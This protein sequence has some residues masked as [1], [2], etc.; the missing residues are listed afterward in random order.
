MIKTI[1]TAAAALALFLSPLPAMAQDA[2]PM[3]D[4]QKKQIEALI[5]D[6]LMANPQVIMDSVE[7]FRQRSEEEANSAYDAKIKASADKLYNNPASPVVGNKDGDVTL[8]EFIDYNC[9][10]C[11]L[12]F[13]DI[14]TLVGEDKNLKVVI[15]EI[16]ILSEAS[17]TAA[18]YALAAHKQDKY[19]DFHTELMRN[20]ANSQMMIDKAAKAVGLDLDKLKKDADSAEVRGTLEANLALARD[21]GISGTPGFIIADKALRGHFGVDALRQAI[22]EA[23]GKNGQ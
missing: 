6:Y 2:A 14:E 11:K 21:V 9:G 8:V 22:T 12:A 3:S 5:H 1:L 15:K 7:K 10:Y 13:K 16:P 18:R 17:Y 4:A 19:W 20:G 23:R